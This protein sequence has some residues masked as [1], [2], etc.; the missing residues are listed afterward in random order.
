MGQPV[1]DERKTMLPQR[2]A[3]FTWGEAVP[4]FEAK[5][6]KNPIFKF[7]SVA[8]RYVIMVLL[9][10][11][12]APDRAG[13]LA[14]LASAGFPD[15]DRFLVR[16]AV[17]TDKSA[18][19]DPAVQA[20]FPK[21]RVF[22][23]ETGELFGAFGARGATGLKPQW[24]L[25]DPDLRMLRRGGVRQID[26][27]QE[28][29]ALL[30]PVDAHAGMTRPAPVLIVPRVITRALCEAL[31]DEY[32]RVPVNRSGYMVQV[33]GKTVGARDDRYKRRFDARIENKDLIRSLQDQIRM[34]L[35]DQIYKAYGFMPTRIERYIVACYRGDDRGFFSAHRDNTTAATAH[36]RFAVTINL[37]DDY[38][39][40][41]V[42]F[43]EF[44]PQEYRAPRGGALVFGCGL[45]HQAN[46]VTRGER[47]ATL[48]FLYDEAGNAL[49][50]KNL[51]LLENADGA[52]SAAGLGATAGKT[53]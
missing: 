52:V 50:H 47:Y 41:T 29:V 38:D 51:H 42:S 15:D 44:G 49:R 43:P 34:R 48:P 10:P 37:T 2:S 17:S 16:F 21:H 27:L 45:L 46:P 18:W 1:R 20:A 28:A 40:G 12:G 53:G 24:L 3:P 14:Q 35:F 36:R 22:L 13:F 30:D 32:Q 25:L 39:G 5:T 26:R 4:H 8:G 23:D 11:V 33:D 6:A 31:V 19:T 7:G 9:P